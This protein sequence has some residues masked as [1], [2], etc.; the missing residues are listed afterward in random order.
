MLGVGDE[1]VDIRV[2]VFSAV[3]PTLDHVIIQCANI[4]CVIEALNDEAVEVRAAAMS[5]LARYVESPKHSVILMGI[6]FVRTF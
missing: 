6:Q 5:V 2:H 1:S 3:T 4:H